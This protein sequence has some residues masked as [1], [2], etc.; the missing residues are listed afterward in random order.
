MNPRRTCALAALAAL[1]AALL[2][3]G[4]AAGS[5][6]AA[7]TGGQAAVTGRLTGK[8]VMEGG[9]LGPGGVQPGE[10]PISG[11]VTFTDV[12]HRQVTVQVASSGRFSVK[13][14]PGRYR[15]SGRSPVIGTNSGSGASEPCSP[16][17]S[18]TMAA[19]H[20]AAVTIT[21]IVP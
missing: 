20:T 3:A 13:L 14:P 5:G 4:C 1:P 18:A 8:L 10:R 19:G 15:V 2:T 9:P 11:T 16:P 7:V 6:Q 12:R 17:E 21:C